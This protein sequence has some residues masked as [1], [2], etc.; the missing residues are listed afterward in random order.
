MII[1]YK[2]EIMSSLLDGPT[3]S[4]SIKNPTLELHLLR[5]TE[6]KVAFELSKFS[7]RQMAAFIIRVHLGNTE[8]YQ[9]NQRRLTPVVV[10]GIE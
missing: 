1:K 3:H 10:I 4:Y 8:I 6:Y 2:A 5:T 7:P 9:C